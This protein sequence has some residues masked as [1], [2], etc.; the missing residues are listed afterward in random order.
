MNYEMTP[1][2]MKLAISILTDVILLRPLVIKKINAGELGEDCLRVADHMIEGT[3]LFMSFVSDFEA[4]PL[5]SKLMLKKTSGIIASE[6]T[7]L[8]EQIE[9]ADMTEQEDGFFTVFGMNIS[10][11]FMDFENWFIGEFVDSL[12]LEELFQSFMHVQTEK[13]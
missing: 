3:A 10:E 4:L 9:A 7:F 12:S 13:E 11:F 6:L 5:D 2:K 8:H 1:E